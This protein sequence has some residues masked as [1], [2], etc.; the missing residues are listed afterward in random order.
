LIILLRVQNPDCLILTAL[1]Q[2]PTQMPDP[3]IVDF[4]RIVCETLKNSGNV[5]VPCFPSGDPT[6]T[7]P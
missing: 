2:T 5:L 3:M 7:L 1:T 4:C 6:D